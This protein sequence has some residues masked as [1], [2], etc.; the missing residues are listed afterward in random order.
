MQV[1][2]AFNIS[3]QQGNNDCVCMIEKHIF[4]NQHCPEMPIFQPPQKPIRNIIYNYHCVDLAVTYTGS[5]RTLDT[6]K[7]VR[8]NGID[9]VFVNTCCEIIT[10]C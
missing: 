8:G 1:C 9:L 3:I 4:Y 2:A 6:T 10:N 7:H 5:L